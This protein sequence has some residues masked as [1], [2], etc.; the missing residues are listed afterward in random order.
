MSI[1]LPTSTIELHE[2]GSAE[3]ASAVELFNSMIEKHPRYVVR[4]KSN[5]DVAAA[6]AYAR[7]NDLPLAVRAGGHSVA[8]HSLVDDGLVIDIRDFSDV[9]VDYVKRTARVGGG[10][11]GAQLDRATQA[12][13]LATTGGR[14][15]STGVG[16]LTLGGGSGWLDRKH[17]LAADNLIGAELVNADGETIRASKSENPDLLWALRGGGGNFGV[18]TA[19]ELQLHPLGPEVYAGYVMYPTDQV[20]GALRNYRD[21]MRDAPE[22][23][24]VGIGLMTPPATEDYPEELHGKPSAFVTG[25]YAGPLDEGEEAMR[26]ISEYGDPVASEWGPMPYVDFQCLFDDPPGYRNYWT[27]EHVHDMPDD[28][29]DAMVARSARIPASPSMLWIVTWGGAI[30]RVSDDESPLSGRDSVFVIHPFFLWEDPAIDAYMMELGR[31]YRD[32]VR[33]L[34]TGDVYLNFVGDE[35]EERVR[36]GFGNHDRLARVKAKYDPHNVF[37]ANQNVRPQS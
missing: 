13:G 8:G 4:A 11:I 16:G 18:V 25:M 35:G 21:V 1:T 5:A 23:L 6:I 24:N 28:A 12:Y 33:G 27:A 26:A 36:K 37:N 31:G 19:L 17:G 14:I 9:H 3:Y 2:P 7:D 15:S 29:I 30:A 20:A 10:A 32:D 22:G 34:A